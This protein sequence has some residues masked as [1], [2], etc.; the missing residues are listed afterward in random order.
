MRRLEGPELDRRVIELG[1]R[2]I[3]VPY[4]VTWTLE[5]VDHDHGHDYPTLERLTD[6]PA[7]LQEWT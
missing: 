6:L 3:H 2:A 4:H 5:E 1:A 7:L